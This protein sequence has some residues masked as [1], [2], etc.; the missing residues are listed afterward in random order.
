VRFAEPIADDNVR[1]SFH[2][3]V[4]R[5][6]IAVTD[7]R[8]APNII[9]HPTSDVSERATIGEGTRIWHEAQVREDARLGANCIVGKGVYIDFGVQIGDNVKIQN[10]AS[11]YHG[12]TIED[13]VFI[14]PHVVF[15]N[16]RVPRAITPDGE[17]KRDDDWVVGETRVR[18]GAS[19]G[20]GS[21]ILPGLTIG[22][23]ALVGAGSVVTRD[24][25][26]HA[27]VVGNPA[28]RIGFACVCGQKLERRDAE[29]ICPA[30][31]RSYVL[32]D[33]GDCAVTLSPQSSEEH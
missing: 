28:K 26:D 2:T 17:L 8:N 22:R 7:I 21:I 16:D 15:T 32:A 29:G 30:C 10:R 24:V 25:P 31:G 27:I 6:G 3:N 33:A 23:F 11:V 12:T 1:A 9:L 4:A 5:G 14:G 20:A 13:G 18:Y 19:I